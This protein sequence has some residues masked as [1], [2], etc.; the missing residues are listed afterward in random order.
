MRR[1]PRRALLRALALACV[2]G[3]APWAAAADVSVPVTLQSI[4]IGKVVTFDRAFRA[5]S[6]ATA[7]V[8]IVH[9]HGGDSARIANQIAYALDQM[10]DL[11]GLPKSIELQE[12]TSPEALASAVRARPTAL[13][14]LSVGL[15][16]EAGS[17]AAAL[18]KSGVLTIGATGAIAERGACLGFELEEGRPKIYVNLRVARAQNVD[19]S[20]G[21]LRLAKLV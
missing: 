10:P 14:Y 2:A 5:R 6:G 7:R 17:I 19:F 3:L 4:L 13:I 18:V 16:D 12:W 15:E 9:K 1:P 21:L 20:S 11:G 8:I